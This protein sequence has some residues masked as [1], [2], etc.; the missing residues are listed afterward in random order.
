L[1]FLKIFEYSEILKEGIAVVRMFQAVVSLMDLNKN[2]EL[3]KL[4]AIRPYF[5]HAIVDVTFWN[6]IDEPLKRTSRH[7]IAKSK[8]ESNE[9]YLQSHTII[10]SP[11]GSLSGAR[12]GSHTCSR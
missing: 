8:T 11:P 5:C 12:S 2:S 9:P 3:L 1:S 4:L 6:V 10:L 7:G